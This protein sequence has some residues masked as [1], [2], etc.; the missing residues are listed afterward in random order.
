MLELPEAVVIARQINQVLPGKRIRFALANQNPHAFAWYTGDP[1]AYS[2]L[3]GEKTIGSAAAFAGVVE[4]P[5]DDV[6]LQIS[7]AMHYHPPG[8]A[9][10]K[11][12]QLLL[13]FEDGSALTVT[14]QMWGGIF[15][16]RPGE[17]CGFADTLLAKERPS[18]LSAE[19]DWAYFNSLFDADTP[20]MSAKEFLA[21]RQRIP[22]L[23]NGVLQDILWTARLHPKRKIAGLSGKE[24]QDLFAAVK[25]V[26]TEIT[27]Q[28]GRDTER[29][30]F[31]CPGGY[32]TILSKNT[33]GTPCPACA[34][35]IRKEAY[36]GGSIYYCPQCQKTA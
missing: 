32:R 21:T 5:A 13:E 20:K 19:F 24:V 30:L 10:P 22:G 29:D 9:R 4:I 26:L 33:A 18:P 31:G 7:A 6:L 28:G 25:T 8:E 23:G 35:V 36:L 16:C 11:K 12:H 2:H 3:L 17:P 1:A 14:V 27:L 15:C 34:A